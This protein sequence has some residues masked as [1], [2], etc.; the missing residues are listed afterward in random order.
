[1][2]RSVTDHFVSSSVTSIG[3]VPLVTSQA[4]GHQLTGPINTASTSGSVGAS[5]PSAGHVVPSRTFHP[6]HS[7]RLD[8]GTAFSALHNTMDRG[9]VSSPPPPRHKAGR[10]SRAVSPGNRNRGC[11]PEISSSSRSSSGDSSSS[12]TSPNHYR[13]CNRDRSLSRRR[14]H[15]RSRHRS[16]RRYSR[17]PHSQRRRTVSRHPRDR[18]LS[19]ISEVSKETEI[20]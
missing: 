19:F 9:R 13:R 5:G 20:S 1:M 11:H 10:R 17:R 18:G 14:S 8:L 3:L 16:G 6:D 12:D 15:R 4:S 7:V 2:S